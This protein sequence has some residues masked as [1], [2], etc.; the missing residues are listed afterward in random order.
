MISPSSYT[1]RTFNGSNVLGKHKKPFS[2][3]KA[4]ISEILPSRF[5]PKL[6]ASSAPVQDTGGTV[7]S[8]LKA[9]SCENLRNS[10]GLFEIKKANAA[11]VGESTESMFMKSKSD[12]VSKSGSAMSLQEYS[13]NS[14]KCS[15]P[16]SA[17]KSENEFTALYKNMHFINRSSL[18]SSIS[19]CSV[20]DIASQFENEHQDL[21][22]HS[23]GGE[24]S[25]HIP[26]HTV[27][28]RVT[29]FEQLI[30][31]SR[32]MPSLDISSNHSRSPTPSPGRGCLSS[33]CSAES[34][35]EPQFKKKQP[36]K[37]SFATSS[38]ALVH[39]TAPSSIVE[40]N[41]P[42]TLVCF[43]PVDTHT[44]SVATMVHASSTPSIMHSNTTTTV[45]HDSYLVTNTRASSVATMVHDSSTSATKCAT[46]PPA[47]T[48][49]T[50]PTD[51]VHANSAPTLV[52]TLSPPTM[53]HA[54]S[55]S[56]MVHAVSPPNTNSSNFLNSA[57]H[58]TSATA[59]MYS[60]S[61]TVY[62]HTDPISTVVPTTSPFSAG[63]PVSP[64]TTVSATSPCSSSVEVL[65]ADISDVSL[66]DLLSAG[67]DEVDRLSNASDDSCGSSIS[68]SQKSKVNSC[69][70][71]CP[72]SYTRFTTIRRHEQQM[73]TTS[74]LK[75]DGHGDRDILS[76][77]VYL[78]SPL[79]FRLKK[80]VHSSLKKAPHSETAGSQLHDGIKHARKG[81]LTDDHSLPVHGSQRK[82]LVPKRLS[83]VDIVGKLST[84]SVPEQVG[85][86]SVV[87]VDCLESLNNGNAVSYSLRH[88]QD[89]SNNE[90][91]ERGS[92][93]I[94]VCFTCSFICV[95]HHLTCLLSLHSLFPWL[96]TSQRPF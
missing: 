94:F 44:T 36:L 48:H 29:A 34:L 84:L 4:C 93:F 3:A 80:S 70:G 91:S 63:R 11:D 75:S 33:A 26:K 24:G 39:P 47:L 51:I 85:G 2:A 25:G 27:S 45:V 55:V 6:A 40:S 17:R 31:R 41:S 52:P 82:P 12:F 19:S 13:L 61:S 60:A 23:T 49:P 92:G 28:S 88:H 43:P 15:F 87:P 21:C 7:G 56:T 1:N 96:L 89:T 58:A 90:Q 69:K 72:A 68:Q 18:H 14:R 83:S 16:S 54:T 53:M 30:Q 42:T 81:N 57:V 38:P 77:N 74:A 5:K 50:F 67:T 73:S 35:L 37:E 9:Q 95:A 71:T 62:S 79:P 22:D 65:T 20:R 78:M 76:R 32:S 86:G 8:Q 66:M 64:S 46:S 10:I 59:V